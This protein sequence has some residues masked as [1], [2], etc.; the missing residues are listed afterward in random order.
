MMTF[1]QPCWSLSKASSTSRSGTR[2]VSI[3]SLPLATLDRSW[4]MASSHISGEA[5]ALSDPAHSMSGSRLN[6]F[7]M[8]RQSWR[9]PIPRRDAAPPASFLNRHKTFWRPGGISQ[10]S[11][12]RAALWFHDRDQRGCLIPRQ[13]GQK[14]FTCPCT[15]PRV[16]ARIGGSASVRLDAAAKRKKDPTIADSIVLAIRLFSLPA[17]IGAAWL[18]HSIC[19]DWK[20]D[21][22]LINLLYLTSCKARS[23][24]ATS[25]S[26]TRR[27]SVSI[28]AWASRVAANSWLTYSRA[29]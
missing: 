27:S 18:G 25:G 15:K 9:T 24:R 26:V 14:P 5:G 11:P 4:R 16:A 6:Y 3:R 28:S 12:L 19:G 29:L 8:V 2:S 23:R 1:L 20:R 13:R 7:A 17:A 10:R 22:M 21:E